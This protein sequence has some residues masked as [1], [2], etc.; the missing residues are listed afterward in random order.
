MISNIDKENKVIELAHDTA[1]LLSEN[2]KNTINE[3]QATGENINILKKSGLMRY[4][5][6]SD[7]GGESI[8]LTDW[9]T[10]NQILA[11]SCL[12][13]ALLW[14][15]HSQQVFTVINHATE[16]I[17]K[18]ILK[19]VINGDN[20]IASITTESEKGGHLLTARTP[21]FERDNKV[22]FSRFAPIVSGGRFAD[23]YL[24]TMKQKKEHNVKL[25]Y[26]DR[27]QVTIKV[28]EDWKGMGMKRTDSLAMELKGT[29]PKSQI[30][31][32]EENFSKLSLQTII[33]IAHIGWSSCWLGAT[34]GVF[35]KVKAVIRKENKKFNTNSDL[36]LD[37]LARIKI[38]IDIVESLLL[39][40]LKKYEQGENNF[41]Y[42]FNILLNNLK[43]VS[44]EELFV[45]VNE[46]IELVGMKLGYQENVLEIERVFRDLRSASLMYS[47]SR[48]NK[49]SGK[50]ILLSK[51]AL[52][53]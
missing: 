37:K 17:K 24:V 19:D 25:I 18:R 9:V 39:N 35:E 51:N 23:S 4:L 27:S 11:S 32:S 29:I 15:M 47:N 41:S 1:K 43:V 20:F 53:L 46:L 22:E 10:I 34:K 3:I 44:S 40:V 13:S 52:L 28:V 42:E 48:L 12:S 49:A 21:I 31:N 14:T 5:V 16:T 8:S 30:I 26:I 7:Y 6:P 33:P 45:A 36:F 38:K 2:N 50:L